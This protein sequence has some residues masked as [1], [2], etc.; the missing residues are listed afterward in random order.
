MG[1]QAGQIYF[2]DYD[3]PTLEYKGVKMD[4]EDFRWNVRAAEDGVEAF[5]SGP[6]KELTESEAY[7][8]ADLV[9]QGIMLLECI[10][11]QYS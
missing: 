9:E 1:D 11:S 10:G 6:F 4:V 3:I 8:K 5:M 7:Q 2:R